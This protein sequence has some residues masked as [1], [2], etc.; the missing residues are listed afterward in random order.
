MAC[1]D[2][3]QGGETTRE[4]IFI[5]GHLHLFEAVSES[6]PRDVH[7][8]FPSELS[9]PVD[10]YITVMDENGIDYAVIVPLS[11][12]DQYL[13]HCLAKYPERLRGIGIYRHNVPDPIEDLARRVRQIG[14]SGLRVFDL[15]AP[16]EEA[17]EDIRKLK[18]FP[19]LQF[20]EREGYILWYYWSEEQ[21]PLLGKVLEALPGLK[22]VMNHLGFTQAGFDVDEL[23]RPQVRS[24]FPP[25]S[26]PAMLEY[27][28]AYPNMYVMFSGEYGF[29]KEAFP[30]LDI[31]PIVRKIYSVFG[32]KRMFWASD[33][34]WVLERPGYSQQL[35]LVDIYL[36]DIP[37][38]ERDNIM[39]ETAAR[40]LG[41]PRG[42][43][44]I[45]GFPPFVGGRMDTC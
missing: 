33:Y 39:G 29:S 3:A 17:V 32:G 23:G 31:K 43:M 34:P 4:K 41:F 9:S 11:A 8:L 19:L 35:E 36:P 21:I 25:P 12:H 20:M 13:A 24:K 40:L 26:I 7:P 15:R 6:Y 44:D 27:G 37:A 30:F 18:I 14:I 42:E 38:S 5:D 1:S 22:I 45:E 2:C 16:G 28:K 10:K